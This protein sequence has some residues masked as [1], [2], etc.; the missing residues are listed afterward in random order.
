MGEVIYYSPSLLRNKNLHC[1][2]NGRRPLVEDDLWRKTSFDGRQPSKEDDFWRKMTFDGRLHLT[3]ADPWRKTTFDRRQPLMEADLW[4][5][6]TFDG[7][8]P[9]MEDDLWWKTTFDG[10]PPLTE[11]DLCIRC[12]FLYYL[13]KMLMTIHLDCYVTTDCKPEMLSGVETGNRIPH[14]EWNLRGIVHAHTEMYAA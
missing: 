4:R 6:T 14:D 13:K 5:K 8:W 2:D 1:N 3:E 9:L 10:Q 11:D 7:R 12:K